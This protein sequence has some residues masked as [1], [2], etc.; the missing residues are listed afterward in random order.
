MGFPS[1]DH[2]RSLLRRADLSS[3]VVPVRGA[4]TGLRWLR[5]PER[6][7]VVGEPAWLKGRHLRGVSVSEWRGLRF[8]ERR[9]ERE[10]VLI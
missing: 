7:Q 6:G 1:S 3:G 9:G 10:R 4:A 5:R 8:L 2:C